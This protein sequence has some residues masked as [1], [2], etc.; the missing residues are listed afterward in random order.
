MS[1][2]RAPHDAQLHKVGRRSSSPTGRPSGSSPAITPDSLYGED[3]YGAVIDEASRMKEDAWVAIQSTLTATRGTRP[4]SET[5]PF[6]HI[7][8]GGGGGLAW[9]GARA[10]VAACRRRRG[11]V[12]FP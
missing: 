5:W 2:Y 8:H 12:I 9:V 11:H 4:S 1:R 10:C 7:L 3:V 6:R